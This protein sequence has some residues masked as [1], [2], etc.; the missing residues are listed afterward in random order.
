MGHNYVG[1]HLLVKLFNYPPNLQYKSIVYYNY[2]ISKH[3]IIYV[4][5]ERACAMCLAMIVL[6][7]TNC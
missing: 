6:F 4:A 5:R 1:L 7:V 2:Y 3:I